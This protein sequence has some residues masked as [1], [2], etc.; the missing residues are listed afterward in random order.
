[1]H[2]TSTPAGDEI[3][4]KAIKEIFSSER[5][6]P[7]ISAIKSSIGHTFAGAGAIETIFGI[8][9]LQNVEYSNYLGYCS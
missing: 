6:K 3:E 5:T 8:L 7:T 4:A 1:M 9:S 2:A